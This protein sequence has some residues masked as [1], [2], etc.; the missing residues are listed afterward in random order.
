MKISSEE[1]RGLPW[2][3]FVMCNILQNSVGKE[4]GQ[5]IIRETKVTAAQVTAACH[6]TEVP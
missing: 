1:G 6:V 5:Y 4:G 2:G 3:P